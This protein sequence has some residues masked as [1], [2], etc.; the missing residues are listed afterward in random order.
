MAM[1]GFVDDIEDLTEDNG[2]FR[3]V[4]YTAKNMLLVLM[5]PRP[6]EEIG[7]EVHPHRR[8]AAQTLHDLRAPEHIDGT[9]H[10]TKSDA[11]ASNEHYD[12]KTE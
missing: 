5:A 3:R 8:Q 1:K 2:D 9:I 4:L 6:G 10:A 12:G 11:G 7:E